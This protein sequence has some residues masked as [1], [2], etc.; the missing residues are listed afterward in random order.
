[1]FNLFDNQ[2]T[3]DFEFLLAQIGSDV[4]ING[5]ETP[6]KAVIT[7][8]TLEANYD[9]RKL[10]TLSPL[11][12]GDIVLFNGQKYMVISEVNDKRYSKYKGIMRRLTHTIIVNSSC[13][14]C[15]LDSFIIASNLGVIDGQV[16]SLSAGEI[17]VYTS[18]YCVNSGLKIGDRFLL[19][20]QAFKITGID[21]FSKKEW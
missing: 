12:R 4:Y 10:A 3:T 14:F 8:T 15:T 20:G 9:D 19:D 6:I 2:N 5:E 7:N 18:Q 13:R 1:M 11:K 17:H 16:L 21:S